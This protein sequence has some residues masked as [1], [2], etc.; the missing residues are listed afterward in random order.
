MKIDNI[1]NKEKSPD[2]ATIAERSNSIEDLKK[3]QKFFDFSDLTTE[4]NLNNNLLQDQ[5][6]IY[7]YLPPTTSKL[8]KLLL[9]N[10]PDVNHIND[11]H[12]HSGFLAN[13]I[14]SNSKSATT[15]NYSFIKSNDVGKRNNNSITKKGGRS[16][17]KKQLFQCSECNEKFL[18]L[19]LFNHI[20][21]VHN[22]F[23]CLYC[24]GFFA[25]AGE[26][27][28]HLVKKHKVQNASFFDE[29]SLKNFLGVKSG[30]TSDRKVK[31]VCCKC[32]T[33]FNLVDSDFHAHRCDDENDKASEIPQH[34]NLA[35]NSHSA[36]QNELN[37]VVETPT[38]AKDNYYCDQA[39]QRW[40]QPN[41]N[42]PEQ[43]ELHES[44]LSTV[45]EPSSQ[46]VPQ[47]N[48]LWPSEEKPAEEKLVPKLTLKIPKAF[49]HQH[50]SEDSLEE[51]S[52]SDDNDRCE[53]HKSETFSQNLS[54]SNEHVYS[55]SLSESDNEASDKILNEAPKK[56]E[57][58]PSLKLKIKNLASNNPES[59]LE[60]FDFPGESRSLLET[61][62]NDVDMTDCPM[63]IEPLKDEA[64]IAEEKPETPKLIII[65]GV[66]ITPANED[67]LTFDISLDESLDKVPIMKLMKICLKVS[68]PLCLY[69][70]HARKIVVNGRALATHFITNHRFHAT[71]ASITA[72]ELHPEKIV[73]KFES[74]I[75]EL[76]NCFFNLE[77]F[78]N[79]DVE[80]KEG[81]VTIS[82]DKLYE[83]F[84][85]R[86]QT[87]I[88][89]EL[90]LH[91]RKMHQKTLI[92][93]LMCKTMFY[94]FSELLCHI[95]PGLPN[96]QKQLDFKFY[97]CLCNLDN[98]PSAFRLM[99]HL[100]KKHYACDVCLEKCSD[101]SKLSSHVCKHKLFHLCY[102]C[103]ISYRNKEDII[104][105]LYWK[106]GTEGIECKKC[107]KKKW[108]HV[109]HFCIPPAAFICQHCEMSF[110]KAMALN[111]HMRL[112][113]DGAK[114][115]CSELG[116]EKKF[117]SK[118]LLL[119]HL[120]R[121]Q[122]EAAA[123]E[124]ENGG[125]EGTVVI[126]L[127]IPEGFCTRT[128]AV[129][130]KRVTRKPILRRIENDLKTDTKESE[131]KKQ[132]EAD[133]KALHNLPE[134]NLNLSE[135]SDSDSSEDEERGPGER[136]LETLAALVEAQI[137]DLEDE[138]PASTETHHPAL[139]DLVKVS[140]LSDSDDDETETK[141]DDKTDETAEPNKMIKD[142]SKT[143]DEQKPTAEIAETPKKEEE[144]EDKLPENVVLHVC[145]SDHDYAILYGPPPGSTKSDLE[146][147]IKIAKIEKQKKKMEKAAQKKIKKP[148]NDD[149]DFSSSDTNSGTSSSSSGS[150]SSGSSSSSTSSD[151]SS[152]EASNN[153]N[154]LR[155]KKFSKKRSKKEKK[156]KGEKE[157]EPPR[158]PDDIIYES[159]LVTD[160]TDTDEE[161]YDEHPLNLDNQM[162]EKRKQ[163]LK[164]GILDG[165]V[166]NSRPSTPSLPPDEKIGK[167]M[168]KKRKKE[169]RK[170]S[171]P[172]K[173]PHNSDSTINPGDA[174][175]S[176]FMNS[177]F[178][179][180]PE[181]P[182]MNKM[183]N[184]HQTSTPNSAPP[185]IELH[186]ANQIRQLLQSTQQQPVLPI[187][188]DQQFYHSQ[189]SNASMD[190]VNISH[191]PSIAS[192]ATSSRKNSDSES[193]LKRSQRK[194]IPNKFYGYT[195]DDESMAAQLAMNP[196]DPFKPIPPPQFIWRKEDLPTK[197]KSP[198]NTPRIAPLKLNLGG[199]QLQ[200]Q[201]NTFAAEHKQTELQ[202][203]N[204][205]TTLHDP[206][207]AY[208]P[209]H[210]LSAHVNPSSNRPSDSDS[211]DEDQLHISEP[212]RRKRK[213][214]S[215]ANSMYAFHTLETPPTVTQPP[216]PRLKLTIGSNNKIRRRNINPLKVSA[217]KKRKISNVAQKKLAVNDETPPAG[218]FNPYAKQY[219]LQPPTRLLQSPSFDQPFSQNAM[220]SRQMIAQERLDK[221]QKL[222]E[223][224]TNTQQYFQRFNHT[225][226]ASAEVPVESADGD[227]REYC[228]CRRSYDEI[229]GMIGCDG[230]SCEIEWFHFEC[231]GILVAPKGNWYC[232]ECQKK[233]TQ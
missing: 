146:D 104:K 148:S 196:N 55:S 61:T 137:D 224:I 38:T 31:A 10:D 171:S 198:S 153:I 57:N 14:V 160:Q 155:S 208:V 54:K 127:E 125:Q 5:E 154:K 32:G 33:I 52:S 39:I 117:V 114:Y 92:N 34:Q 107:L 8:Q 79:Q 22:K 28:K 44:P 2:K 46:I 122:L 25:D 98:I 102:R 11:L 105:H 202:E 19:H 220:S 175:M 109:Y 24:Y 90:Y 186:Q 166:E 123:A 30:V 103:N 20:K 80:K 71:V 221:K 83:C 18:K 3:S 6:A 147:L 139:S 190:Y 209:H 59:V 7:N 15:K 37:C 218:L 191:A 129:V 58:L 50:F 67:V 29:V 66:V 210:N 23:T 134:T 53:S 187:L 48:D 232:P 17:N 91:N 140:S 56:L 64:E 69:C 156:S 168:K 163:L 150:S 101:Q 130:F 76:E 95:C 115:P 145:Q 141:K 85:C 213:L 82:H 143:L 162:A 84:Q 99:V 195:S 108:P 74:C 16:A 63:D 51:G 170:S 233:Q 43:Q 228:Y 172:S 174:S 106:H 65:D 185:R 189:A 192:S 89:K 215:Q 45:Y 35:E 199:D 72:E 136:S 182:L 173:R 9:N 207:P 110:S 152:S 113:E 27:E 165:I 183:Y 167:K 97:C 120:E 205:D 180:P 87:S 1:L 159:D 217:A 216:I 178:N 21:S 132:E 78:D 176:Q 116:C 133:G 214:P 226:V 100:R 204:F 62:T 70:N 77:T 164:G 68:F 124:G 211:S 158:D 157:P 88:H 151:S 230:D 149:D 13:N 112:H 206:Q 203:Y 222:E 36:V 60:N 138:L 197:N 184:Y 135:S 128:M 231:V 94:N 81:H 169:H 121:H 201:L 49:Q 42:V 93:C 86:F 26:L 73:S 193:A 225:Q 212:R 131:L 144:V 188:K 4:T 126:P 177:L 111:V 96:K 194:R 200:Q 227:G 179:H 75:D 119:R 118:K 161:F 142:D 219:D 12:Q 40:C 229:H 47:Q 41:F 181:T 223:A